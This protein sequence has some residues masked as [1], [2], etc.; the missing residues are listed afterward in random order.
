MRGRELEKGRAVFLLL[1]R[2]RE[3]S[4]ESSFKSP[5]LNQL[6]GERGREILLFVFCCAREKPAIVSFDLPALLS[7]SR[8]TLLRPEKLGMRICPAKLG[9]VRRGLLVLLLLLWLLLGCVE[10]E[11]CWRG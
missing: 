1:Q 3:R 11:K 8:E 7:K 6:F 5:H 2:E 9:R 4:K 10:M